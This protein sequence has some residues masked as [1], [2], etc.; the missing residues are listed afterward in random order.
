M[1]PLRVE[2]QRRDRDPAAT[3]ERARPQGVA[4]VVARSDEQAHV[5]TGDGTGARMQFRRRDPGEPERGTTHQRALGQGCEQRRLRRPHLLTRV[6]AAHRVSRRGRYS[7]VTDL[8]RLRGLST[9]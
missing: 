1:G 3:Q 5:P 2:E 7:T 9:S 8:A 4:A 6:V